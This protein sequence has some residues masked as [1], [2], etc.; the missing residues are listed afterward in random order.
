MMVDTAMSV[1]YNRIRYILQRYEPTVFVARM[2]PRL[3][4]SN[5]YKFPAFISTV[6]GSIGPLRIVDG[7]QDTL[8]VY[9]T[10]ADR[11]QTL[12]IECC[13]NPDVVN[14]V[15]ASRPEDVP[16]DL[17]GATSPSRPVG[18]GFN[19]NVFGVRPAVAAEGGNPAV[20]AAVYIVGRGTTRYY[21][22]S[23]GRNLNEYDMTSLLRECILR[24][25]SSH[26]D[27]TKSHRS[28]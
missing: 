16:G 4:L 27:F 23:L 12:R 11:S 28:F 15:I 20:P 24:Y 22:T 2:N 6:L 14:A 19:V 13:T 21:C 9:A 1:T 17:D 3:P 26:L 7:L 10:S 25:D 18:P 5:K 8:V